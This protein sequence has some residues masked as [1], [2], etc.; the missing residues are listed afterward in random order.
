M[1]RMAG[2]PHTLTWNLPLIIMDR[3]LLIRLLNALAAF[4]STAAL[5]A[6]LKMSFPDKGWKVSTALAI[7]TS[8]LV[9]AWSKDWDT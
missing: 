9:C 3:P 5:A 2:P 7:T 1:V 6:M 4:G 8:C